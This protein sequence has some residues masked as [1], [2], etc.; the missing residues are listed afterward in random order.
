MRLWLIAVFVLC[1]LWPAQAKTIV[2]QRHQAKE[3]PQLRYVTAVLE[4]AIRESGVAYSPRISELVMVQSRGLDELRRNTGLIDLSWAMT[5][6]QREREVLPIRIPI[7]RGLIGWR[8]ALLKQHRLADFARIDS[9]QALKRY[10]GDQYESLFKMLAAGRFDYF[11]RSLIEVREEW[12]A[13][14]EMGLAVEPTLLIRYPAAL[15]F[16]VSKQNRQLAADLERGLNKAV[17]EGKLQ[18]LFEQ[19]FGS[20][21]KELNVS[22]RRVIELRNPLLPPQTPLQRPEL[23]YRPGE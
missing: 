9:L 3:D 17:R 14:A 10:R 1:C 5:S 20:L 22:G 21:L 15:Y 12:L 7:D 4:L 18:A 16:F 19:H 23:W 6:A 8:V 13:H 11:P 2:Y